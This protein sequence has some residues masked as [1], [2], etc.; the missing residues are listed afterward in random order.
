MEWEIINNGNM[1][2]ITGV[3][4]AYLIFFIISIIGVKQ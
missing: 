3:I 4:L 1:L 2:S